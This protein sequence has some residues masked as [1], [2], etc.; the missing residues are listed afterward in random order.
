M[1]FLLPRLRYAAALMLR[2]LETLPIA[3]LSL[4]LHHPIF[5]TVFHT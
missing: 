1:P 4:Q 3:S 2:A 5:I